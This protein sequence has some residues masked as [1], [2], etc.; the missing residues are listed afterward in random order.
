MVAS[1]SF[2][3]YTSR[4]E[5]FV[6]IFLLLVKFEPMTNNLLLEPA[7]YYS[8]SPLVN[9]DPNVVLRASGADFT[10]FAIMLEE[11]PY[12]QEDFFKRPLDDN[13]R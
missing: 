3:Y 2:I 13:N 9:N 6:V 11:F 12:I 5:T 1:S 4:L 8:E 7:H 10:L